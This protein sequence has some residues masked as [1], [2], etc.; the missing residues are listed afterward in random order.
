MPPRD[1]LAS[2]VDLSGTHLGSAPGLALAIA[3]GIVQDHG[4]SVRHD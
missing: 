1:G 3:L 4:D 2:R